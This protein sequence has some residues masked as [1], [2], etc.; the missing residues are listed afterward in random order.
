MSVLPSSRLR[1]GAGLLT[2]LLFALGSWPGRAAETVALGDGV[3]LAY[4]TGTLDPATLAGSAEG[5]T[6]TVDG[7]PV[8]TIAGLRLETRGA[9][10]DADF[11]VTG[12]EAKG[13]ADIAG[14]IR[15]A[16]VA[17]R[18]LP[19]GSLR[20]L[21]REMNALEE[22]DF[23]ALAERLG[24]IAFGTLTLS[25]L[26]GEDELSH[27][28]VARIT[29][30]GGGEGRATSVEISDGTLTEK[31]E[32]VRFQ[33]GTARLDGLSFKTRTADGFSLDG[34][35]IEG[36]T[37]DVA[38]AALRYTAEMRQLDGGIPYSALSTLKVTD[39][40][41]KPGLAPDPEL[42]AFFKDLG[43]AEVRFQIEGRSTGEPN[44]A[45][46]EAASTFDVA[47]QTGDALAVSSRAQIP[48]VVWQ[49]LNELLAQDPTKVD[50][51]GMLQMMASIV[52]VDAE[53]TLTAGLLA[54]RLVEAAARDSGLE[55]VAMRAMIAEE[56]EGALGALPDG[57]AAFRDAILG[58]IARS[59]TIRLAFKPAY[60]I[61][62]TALLTAEEQI[63]A[64]WDKLNIT[65]T[66]SER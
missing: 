66:H 1:A 41:I 65:V 39:L 15:L 35:S 53:V 44:G 56:A 64:L 13:I 26:E 27:F 30:V 9:I 51:E 60:P 22:P 46:L 7:E 21:A 47:S 43:E 48:I 20:A 6:V 58:F 28:K 25:G 24:L 18:D 55:P 14:S 63:D 54:D 12:L 29:A 3:V 45:N 49:L 52:L 4:N 2:A 16:G 42:A 17:G 10:A 33:I 23:A 5:V 61:P 34:F 59:G 57:G 40:T 11:T 50:P 37:L 19:L 32:G 38:I 62:V 31:A 8:A 36:N